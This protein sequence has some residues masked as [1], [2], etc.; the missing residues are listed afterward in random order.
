MTRKGVP[1]ACDKKCSP[2]CALKE[3][4]DALW[5]RTHNAFTSLNGVSGDGS[6][7]LQIEAGENISLEQSGNKIKITGE[8]GGVEYTARSPLDIYENEIFA[9]MG[10]VQEGWSWLVSA[11]NIDK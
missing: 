11:D 10:P 4:L 7:N 9:R 3:K 1:H 5:D 2:W 8:G 6:G